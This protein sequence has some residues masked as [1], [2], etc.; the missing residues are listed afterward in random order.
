MPVASNS[1]TVL[2]V[3]AILSAIA[4]TVLAFIFIVPAKKREKLNKIGKLLHDIVNFRFLI[5]EKILQALYIFATAYVI[6]VGFGMLFVVINTGWTREWMGGYGL[7]VMILGPIAIRIAYE[8]MMM[9]V[10]LV[11][12]VIQINNKLKTTDDDNADPFAVGIETIKG[13]EV[14]A[15]APVVAPVAAPAPAPAGRFC[16]VCG[17]PLNADGTCPV[18]NK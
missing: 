12:N 14:A 6:F 11:K 18:C 1:T 15:P 3:L 16:T 13:E 8:L 9:A 17:N 10:L 4:A 7:L 5:I 2:S